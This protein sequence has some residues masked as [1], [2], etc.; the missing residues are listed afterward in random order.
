MT[1]ATVKPALDHDDALEGYQA[2]G[3][4]LVAT[5]GTPSAEAALRAAAQLSRHAQSNVVVLTVMEPL[6]LVAAD[7]GMMIPPVDSDQTRRGALFSRVKEQ[8]SAMG[9]A[10]HGWTIEIRDGDPSTVISRAARELK[11]R[12]IVVG[13]GHHEL[14][15]RLFGGETALHTLRLA[16]VPVLAVPPD[17]T[18]LPRRIIVATDFSFASVRTARVALALIDTATMVYLVHVAPRMELQPEAFA[19]WMSL[20]GEGV[21]PAFERIRSELALP[22]RVAVETVSRQGK[23]SRELLE[24][25]RSTQADMI[26]TGSRGA[27]LV[28]RL[29]VGSTATGLIRGAHCAVL[30]VPTGSSAERADAWPS[31][32]RVTVAEEHWASE[33]AAF[34]KRNIGRRTALE[35][36]DPEMGAQAQEHDYPFLG[37]AYDHHDQRVEIMLGDF[38]GVGRHLTRGIANVT[39]IDLLQD[40]HGRDWILRV[41][42]GNGQTILTLAR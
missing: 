10:A 1:T 14:L 30:A 37:A 41:V 42:H 32:D 5:D 24:F 3:P 31:Q 6:P 19:A 35:V 36:D 13:L 22:E 33:L 15:D 2:L 23:P 29:L 20:Y 8:V 11:S 34:T 38:K 26:V 21:G 40:E 12:L 39:A 9:P 27:G 16:R 25:A 7:Y 18:H 17:F 28:D 4:I